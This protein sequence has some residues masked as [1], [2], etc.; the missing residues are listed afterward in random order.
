MRKRKLH[1]I[2]KIIKRT[3][4]IYYSVY[5]S[6]SV[7]EQNYCGGIRPYQSFRDTRIKKFPTC[8][9]EKLI[10]RSLAQ[11]QK[12]Y[13]LALSTTALFENTKTLI[14]KLRTKIKLTTLTKESNRTSTFSLDLINLFIWEK[15]TRLVEI[16]NKNLFKPMVS[17]EISA[18]A[19]VHLP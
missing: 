16:C 11:K 4:P 3:Y 12:Y 5:L 8:P 15:P 2:H 9:G 19:F 1:E 7:V 14:K 10:L 17:F 6:T 13:F 18:I